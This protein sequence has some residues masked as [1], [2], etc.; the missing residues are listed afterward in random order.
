[1]GRVA[2]PDP[3]LDLSKSW[4][5]HPDLDLD[6]TRP[7]FCRDTT[8]LEISRPY[9][10]ASIY[11]KAPLGIYDQFGSNWVGQK[12]TSYDYEGTAGT[13]ICGSDGRGFESDYLKG[14]SF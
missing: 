13:K 12:E 3:N 9:L 8:P 11:C 5:G 10:L 14:V 7:N 4:N 6:P 1:M 2:L